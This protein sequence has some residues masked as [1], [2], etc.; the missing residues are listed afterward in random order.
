[1]KTL[2]YLSITIFFSGNFLIVASNQL[3]AQNSEDFKLLTSKRHSPHSYIF[4]IENEEAEVLYKKG[5]N[6]I[7]LS[8][9]HTLV[10]AYNIDSV[11]RKPLD[12]GHYLFVD[13]REN[14]LHYEIISENQ[15]D[16]KLLNN[17]TD[18]AILVHDMEGNTIENCEV[19]LEQKKLR[20]NTE[21]KTF[22]HRKKQKD[23]WVKVNYDGQSHFFFIEK[24]SKNSWIKRTKNNVIYSTPIKYLWMPIRNFGSTIVRSIKWGEPQGFVLKLFGIFDKYYREDSQ[25]YKS[26][27]YKKKFRGF[28]VFNQPKFQPHDTVKLKAFITRKKGKPIRKKLN[29]YIKQYGAKNTYLSKVSPYRK[30]GYSYQFFLH[31]SLQLTLDRSAEIILKYKSKEVMSTYLNFEDY[32]LDNVTFTSRIVKKTVYKGE[33]QSVI[34]QAKDANNLNVLDGKANITVL[35]QTIHT[36]YSDSLFIPDTLWQH[37][38]DLE[39]IGETKVN[40]PDSIFGNVDLA[41]KIHTFFTNSDNEIQQITLNGKFYNDFRPMELKLDKDS[42]FVDYGNPEELK[43][44]TG[45]LLEWQDNEI[46]SEQKIALTEKVKIN[47]YA[48]HYYL[49]TESVEMTVSMTD[50]SELIECLTHRTKDSVKIIMENPRKLPFWYTIYRNNKII[51]EGNGTTL[52]FSRK[53]NIRENYFIAYNYVW[54]GNKK[55]QNYAIPYR[56]KDLDVKIIHPEK[57]YPGQEVEMNILVNNHAGK[58]MKNI[59]LTAYAYTSKFKP[60]NSPDLPLWYIKSKNRKYYNEFSFPYHDF[61]RDYGQM[62][63]DFDFWEK[64][65]GLD[66]L[67]YYHFLY[68]ENGFYQCQLPAVDSI[69]QFS[70]YV[71]ANGYGIPVYTITL[72][73]QLIYFKDSDHLN[74]YAFQLDSGEHKLELRTSNEYLKIDSFYIPH[75]KKTIFSL[76]L[77]NLPDFVKC[78]TLGNF[79][80]SSEQLKL[81]QSLILYKNKFYADTSYFKQRDHFYAIPGNAGHYNY[82]HKTDLIIGPFR[83]LPMTFVAPD[84]FKTRLDWEPFYEYDL[85]PGKI[86]MKFNNKIIRENYF[87]KDRHETPW[88]NDWVLRESELLKPLRI[89]TKDTF[90]LPKLI[91]EDIFTIDYFI[92]QNWEKGT[93]RKNYG[94]FVFEVIKPNHRIQE[95]I[96]FHKEQLR[97]KS[98]S[99]N[100]RK[101]D[102]LPAGNYE[103]IFLLDSNRYFIKKQIEIVPNGI[104][105]LRLD[106]QKIYTI[107]K[108]FYKPVPKSDSVVFYPSENKNFIT[109]KV[110]DMD[111]FPLIGAIIQVKHQEK[112]VF[113][114]I[115]GHFKVKAKPGD[116]LMINCSDKKIQKIPINAYGHYQVALQTIVSLQILKEISIVGYGYTAQ[117]KRSLTGSVSKTSY[118]GVFNASSL[119]APGGYKRITGNI[120]DLEDGNPL[121][122]VSILIKG[123]ASGTTSDIDG[124]YSIDVPVG[125]S[126]I[127]SYI[128]YTTRETRVKSQSRID[129]TL[130]PDMQ[131]LEE[132]VVVGYGTVSKLGGRASGVTV[133]KAPTIKIRGANTISAENNPLI[134]I[135]GVPYEGKLS[136][137]QS[138]SILTIDVLKSEDASALYGSR[139]ANGVMIVVTKSGIQPKS[140]ENLSAQPFGASQSQSGL[141]Q[142]F[143]DHA[144]W[145]PQLVTDQFG[146]ATFKAKFPDDITGWKTHVI[147]VGKNK[148][149]GKTSSF[150]QSFKP[151]AANLALP[152]FLVNGDSAQV[153]G[154]ILNYQQDSVKVNSF[155]E[156]NNQKLN[157]WS[158]WVKDGQIDSVYISAT[159]EDTIAV[160]YQIERENG[161]FDGELREIPV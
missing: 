59:D 124:N 68:P 113:S 60:D 85:Y 155:F 79:F 43:N 64:T 98:I 3:F 65:M 96:V 6:Q 108:P 5:L 102:H 114:G 152:R 24:N 95:I 4:R 97:V 71:V 32:E 74:K 66:S 121:P 118:G 140:S 99:G 21:T 49:N 55:E 116:T 42:L 139:A 58:P 56:R 160:K 136:D 30:G 109:G 61:F 120:F 67:E 117:T 23:G 135:N 27:K 22:I 2:Y 62:L 141:R 29:L 9:F 161:Y 7:D 125:A 154:K 11:Y 33:K 18:L 50:E 57:V 13:A 90:E 111:G 94:N 89:K 122:G 112:G 80:T 115:G 81:N 19:Y 84:Y 86:K 119:I 37:I 82:A 134:I 158:H 14:Q 87:L 131:A 157:T 93:G 132:I 146:N 151:L 53:S 78:D 91:E 144:F 123:T 73:D 107:E 8:Y 12:F 63:L 77:A 47:P 41:Y 36:Y 52:D 110:T 133:T 143:S 138:D 76:D 145:Q 101:I 20:F 40:I 142:Y 51:A 10:N 75:Q 83:P 16:I 150:I 148:L 147:A 103:I 39:T 126:L 137:F 48:T 31:D 46:V 106:P 45:I 35:S 129:M 1:M 153:I 156:L 26:D 104:N 70:P 130:I 28:M 17:Q 25:D 69:T 44:K 54:A 159:S 92:N 38:V 34:L 72:D 100:I 149:S 15:A 127:F 105:F 128:G 88:L